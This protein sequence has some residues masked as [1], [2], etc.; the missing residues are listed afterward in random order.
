M[1]KSHKAV[2]VALIGGVL[3]GLLVALASCIGPGAQPK[4]PN[5]EIVLP[6]N[7]A[8]TIRDQIVDVQSVAIDDHAG[9]IRIELWVDG[10][11]YRVDEAADPKGVPVFTALQPWTPATIGGHYLTAKAETADGRVSES[12]PILVIV[13][14]IP[15]KTPT[16]SPTSTPTPVPPTFTATPE[17]PTMTFTPPP[18]WTFTPLPPPS[19]TP[20]SVVMPGPTGFPGYPSVPG[21]P[22]YPGLPGGYPGYPG[23]PSQPIYPP[24]QPPVP[25]GPSLPVLDAPPTVKIL[26]PS[27]GTRVNMGASVQIRAWAADDIGLLRLELLIDGGVYQTYDAAGQPMTEVLMEWRASVVGARTIEVR[28]YDSAWQVSAPARIMILVEQVVPTSGPPP[29]PDTVPPSVTIVSPP[30]GQQIQSGQRIDVLI[31]ATDNVGVVT[32]EL[33]ADGMPIAG[34]SWPA[35]QPIRQWTAGWSSAMPGRHELVAR[36]RDTAGNQGQSAP[37]SVVIQSA[38][39]PVSGGRLYFCSQQAGN[40]DIYSIRPD[41]SDLRQITQSEF[42]ETSPAVSRDGQMLAYEREGAVW[43]IP[44]TGGSPVQLIGSPAGKPAWSPNRQQIAFVRNSQIWIYEYAGGMPRQLTSG[45]FVYDAPNYAPDGVRLACHS[46]QSSPESSIYVLNVTNGSVM[47]SFTSH[48]GSESVP[49]YSPDGGRIAFART[50]SVDAGIYVMR[51]DGSSVLRVVSQGWSPVWSPDGGQL[52]YVVPAGAQAEL[53]VV[54]VD[55]SNPRRVLSGIS[56]ERIAWGP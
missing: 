16:A 50:G 28:A 40:L 52:A 33:W 27:D 37:V 45:G 11:I 26:Y 56:L 3:C 24:V 8:K 15:T 7:G 2:W 53:W 25:G 55:G 29:A 34:E 44:T 19:P 38:P 49:V 10:E 5:V 51:S 47:Q 9:V 48:P 36:A 14:D 39:G 22:G 35:P 54:N 43:T 12:K 6:K 42:P 4:G 30:T 32:M 46:W 41:A 21:Y 1:R 17:P 31:S 13:E 20:P 23:Y 18:T